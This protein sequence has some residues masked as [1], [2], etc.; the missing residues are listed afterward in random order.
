MENL[1]PE[2]SLVSASYVSDNIQILLLAFHYGNLTNLPQF[3][4]YAE[5]WV[6]SHIFF[7]SFEPSQPLLSTPCSHSFPE[8]TVHLMWCMPTKLPVAMETNRLRCVG[9]VQPIPVALQ[10]FP[11]DLKVDWMYECFFFFLP[12]EWTTSPLLQKALGHSVFFCSLVEY[13]PLTNDND[14]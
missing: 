12:W 13:I 2:H 4:I 5:I 11:A 9:L 10:H 6:L 14:F 3:K 8:P 1:E 7:L